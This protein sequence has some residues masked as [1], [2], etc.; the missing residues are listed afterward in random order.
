M[1]EKYSK[2]NE[3]TIASSPMMLSIKSNYFFCDFFLLEN[4]Q[5]SFT[6]KHRCSNCTEG[7]IKFTRLVYSIRMSLRLQ[8]YETQIAQNYTLICLLLIV[9]RLI[10]HNNAIN[11]ISKIRSCKQVLQSSTEN[12][13]LIFLMRESTIVK[14]E[15][16]LISIHTLLFETHSNRWVSN[17]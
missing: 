7:W 4:K 11:S 2:F 12:W 3:G 14:F 13:H 6:S 17:R 10:L 9:M 8:K 1:G 16:L 5:H 15:H